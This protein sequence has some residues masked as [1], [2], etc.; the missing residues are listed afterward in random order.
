M[1]NRIKKI[2]TILYFFICP[3]ELVINI[4]FGSSTKYVGILVFLVW[5]LE[6]LYESI[7]NHEA[8]ILPNNT[9]SIII[10]LAICVF[11]LLLGNSSEL[12]SDYLITYLEMGLFVIILTQTI[13]SEK[14]VSH[15]LLAYCYGSIFMAILFLIFGETSYLVR[16]SIVFMGKLIDPNQV[17]ANIIPGTII[18][19]GY[20][21]NKNTRISFR[22]FS[23]MTFLLT[24]Y[25]VFMTGSRGGLVSLGG[26]ML[27][28]Y[29]SLMKEMNLK[30]LLFLC[31]TSLLIW[32]AFRLLPAGTTDRLLGF[33]S[34]TEKY[35]NGGNRLTIWKSM[36]DEFDAQWIIGHG[37]GSTITFFRILT[38]KFQGVHN[39]FLLVLYEVGI[40]GFV[41]WTFP[42]ISMLRYN[43]LKRN[44]V[45]VGILIASLSCS[46]FLDS[47]N[48]RYIWN[49]LILCIMKCNLE[50]HYT[51]ISEETRLCKYIK[52]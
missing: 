8:I 15:F 38:G 10:W 7:K 51:Q 47:L 9:I 31:L 37:V 34:Y 3:C 1:I 22:L 2:L 6:I 41:F 4:L 35:A 33:D 16:S 52:N 32:Y 28:I 18:S 29:L 50:S 17:A 24:T 13:W 43:I 19:L 25:L 40:L 30:K 5:F 49:A 44:Y 36:L 26:G 12:T 20:F 21:A 39:T 45:M 23:I 11:S 27:F 42:Y 48:L 46:F 14:D